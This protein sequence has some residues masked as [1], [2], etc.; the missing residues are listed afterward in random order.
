MASVFSRYFS[1]PTIEVDGVITLAQRIPPAGEPEPDSVLHVCI[2]G[3]TLDQLAR[4][5]YDNEDL[6][7]RIADANPRRFFTDW[8]AGDQVIIPPLRTATRTPRG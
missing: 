8:R 3:E 7:W 6:W 5:Y 2:G 1:T 4:R